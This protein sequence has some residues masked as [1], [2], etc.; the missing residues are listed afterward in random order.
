MTSGPGIAVGRPTG[1]FATSYDNAGF[2][3]T[4][5]RRQVFS[6]QA[7]EHLLL[8]AST[9]TTSV[10]PIVQ[11][12]RRDQRYKL[13]AY[14]FVREGL[15]YAHRELGLGCSAPAGEEPPPD[16]HVT[17]Q[18]LSEA[19]RLYAL[20]QFGYLA[21]SVLNSWG[22][23][24]TGDFGEIVYN[25]IHINEMKKSERDRRE[26][27]DDVY[28]FEQAFVKEFAIAVPT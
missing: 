9:M 21:K 3:K 26:D 22:V 23:R 14:Q 13:E 18:Q 12:L 25:L 11:L 15:E 1:K 17:G 27:F 2:G 20:E 24:A 6:P 28:D 4:S 5:W 10:P 8:V 7:A 16:A 19:L